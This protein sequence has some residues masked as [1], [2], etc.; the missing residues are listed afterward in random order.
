MSNLYQFISGFGVKFQPKEMDLNLILENYWEKFSILF[1]NVKKEEFIKWIN[2]DYFDGWEETLNYNSTGRRELK[3][4]YAT[5]RASKPKKLLE[6][7]THM[8]TGTKHILLALSKNKEEGYECLVTT[9]DVIDFV[10]ST[11]LYDYPCRKLIVNSLE[12]LNNENDYDFVV[13]DGSHEVSNVQQELE[14]FNSMTNLKTLWAHDYYLG[15]GEVGKVF[16]NYDK[17]IFDISSPFIEDSYITGFFI[18]I[19]K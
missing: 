8:G 7:G 10:G 15:N 1:P 2:E 9:L 17:K 3:M 4:L 13:Q 19:K 6:I 12:H 11:I 16:E 14:S 18:G 5:I